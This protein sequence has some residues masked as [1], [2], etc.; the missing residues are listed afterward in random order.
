MPSCLAVDP[1]DL[2]ARATRLRV[3]GAHVTPTV[4]DA[5]ALHAEL[6]SVGAAAYA[7]LGDRFSTSWALALH[8]LAGTL[9]DLASRLDEAAV[10]YA[11][12]DAMLAEA[13]G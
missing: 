10:T 9:T 2:A 4:S 1:S 7:R 8:V 3:L 13:F 12:F 6:A 5:E 11:A